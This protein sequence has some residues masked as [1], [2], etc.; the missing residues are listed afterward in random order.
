MTI[1]KVLCC[2]AAAALG[3]ALAWTFKDDISNGICSVKKMICS[4]A[5]CIMPSKPTVVLVYDS[6]CA[7]DNCAD[8][9]NELEC[10]LADICCIANVNVIDTAKASQD[11]LCELDDYKNRFSIGTMPAILILTDNGD[12]TAKLESPESVF[13]ASEF[14]EANI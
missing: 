2:T 9:T 12:L 8:I 11:E 1:K 5:P 13:A 6:N 10:L 4:K 7:K 14:I 3:G